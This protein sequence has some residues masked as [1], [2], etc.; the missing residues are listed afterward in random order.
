MFSKE[1]TKKEKTPGR[2]DLWTVTIKP[3]KC[4]S[5]GHKKIVRKTAERESSI[6]VVYTVVSLID[7][8]CVPSPPVDA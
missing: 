7:R 2:P 1:N 8:G 5:V 4:F 3:N 6:K